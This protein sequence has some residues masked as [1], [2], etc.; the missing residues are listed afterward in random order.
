M[1][2]AGFV[3]DALAAFLRGTP[4]SPSPYP[5]DIPLAEVPLLRAVFSRVKGRVLEGDSAGVERDVVST[6]RGGASRVMKVSTS[7]DHITFSKPF[8]VL[9]SGMVL[10]MAE[11]EVEAWLEE[12][13]AIGAKMPCGSVMDTCEAVRGLTGLTDGVVPT[14]IVLGCRRVFG[15]PV[16]RL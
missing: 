6:P 10:I 8:W 2:G 14:D 16:D 3:A 13:D 7:L 9:W 4:V 15:L 1:I 5:L 11:A 12:A